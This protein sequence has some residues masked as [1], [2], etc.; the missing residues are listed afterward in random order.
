MSLVIHISVDETIHK[1][2]F[3]RKGYLIIHHL[4]GAIIQ[5]A[6]L[7]IYN[8]HPLEDGNSREILQN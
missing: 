3:Y 6:N 1:G 8:C 4:A 7:V 2:N 5:V